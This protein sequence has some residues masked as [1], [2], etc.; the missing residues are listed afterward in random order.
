VLAQLNAESPLNGAA[1]AQ[2][3]NAQ[4]QLQRTRTLLPQQPP[5]SS[6]TR[7]TG[8]QQVLGTHHARSKALIR[9]AQKAPFD[10]LGV[11]KGQPRPTHQPVNLWCPDHCHLCASI[12]PAKLPGRTGHRAGHGRGGGRLSPALVQGRVGTLEPRIDPGTRTVLVQAVVVTPT[13]C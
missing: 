5:R 11:R 8:Y 4:A 2:A 10:V 7:L 3:S 1:Q 12:T 13:A 6:W 9:K